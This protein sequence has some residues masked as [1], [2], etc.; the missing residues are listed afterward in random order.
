MSGDARESWKK[1]VAEWRAEDKI[2]EPQR[3]RDEE[4]R[5]KERH[6]VYL[7]DYLRNPYRKVVSGPPEASAFIKRLETEYLPKI[8][9]VLED[10]ISTQDGP[11]PA[12][13]KSY[14]F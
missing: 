5:Y 10:A 14:E 7:R 6:T 8:K 13:T 12:Q 11:R 3:L 9:S 2:A 1:Q 4:I